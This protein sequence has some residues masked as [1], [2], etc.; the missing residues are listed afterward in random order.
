MTTPEQSYR[1]I[2][3]TQ[4]QVAIVDAAD[5]EWLS[6]WSWWADWNN[7]AK[8]FYAVRAEHS[9]KGFHKIYM[10]RQI[11]GLERGDPRRADHREPLKTL[12]NKRE[13]LRL[14][15]VAEN[16]HNRGKNRNNTT[17]YKGVILHKNSGLYRAEIMV[18][19]KRI[20]LGYFEKVEDASDAYK[21]AAL[22]YHKG[23]AR[24]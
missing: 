13:N 20:Y 9:C 3:L 16:G 11:L 23:F 21:A 12:D 22:E 7:N 1:E 8:L 18:N 5:Y 14:A 17:G 4:G 15:T 24:T 6:Q 19:R 10:H 2:P